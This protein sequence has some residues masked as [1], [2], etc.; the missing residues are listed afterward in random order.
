MAERV[1]NFR[2]DSRDVEPTVARRIGAGVFRSDHPFQ[3]AAY[4]VKLSPGRSTDA[5]HVSWLTSERGVLMLADLLP[6]E[7]IQE[8]PLEASFHL[9][10]GW[11][12]SPV[13]PLSGGRYS[14]ED[15]MNAV[16]IV[17]PS[18]KSHSKTVGATRLNV[19]VSGKWN[20]G[21]QKATEAAAKVFKKYLELTQFKLPT[22]SAL[23]IMPMPSQKGAETWQAQ[24]RGST[25]LLLI[26]Q[27]ADFKNWIGQ[28]EVI[29]THELLHLWVPNALKLKGDYD[30]FFEGFT[31]YQALLT[32]LDLKVISFDEYLNTL[33]RVYDSY[34]AQQDRLSLIE[35][36]EQRWTGAASIVY[37]KGMLL[38][39]LYDLKLRAETRGESGLS[40]RY[41]DLFRKYASKTVDANEA[42]M[43]LLIS[44]PATEALL[45][46]YVEGRGQIQLSE[47][48]KEHG[49]TLETESVHTFLKVAPNP[50][51][52]QRRVLKSL[53]Y[54]Q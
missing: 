42:I 39:F 29:F 23:L 6:M 46:S 43:S 9:P 41:A 49:I 2:D 4:D 24:T 53:G 20:F 32:A 40:D 28:L 1:Q 17:G 15:P 38:A 18:L 13:V 36:S 31:L 27:H 7:V 48:L 12:S 35:A 44:S 30:W 19:I 21:I 5:S 11:E 50:T 52:D 54:R 47:T 37:D 8:G 22:P 16:L 45:K 51:K 25:L 26:N 14:I 34:R 33:G 3:A 10:A